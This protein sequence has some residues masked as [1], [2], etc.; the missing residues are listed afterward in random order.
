MAKRQYGVLSYGVFI[1]ILAICIATFAAGLI[2]LDEVF[3]LV[4]AFSG[5]WIVILAG[6]RATKPEKYER[7]A[8]STFS[9]GTLITAVGTVWFLYVRGFA[10]WYLLSALLLVLGILTMAAVL[11][12]R[13]K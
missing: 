13:R 1:V 6:I 11:R 3:P 7:G 4:L 5:V 12:P 9:W 8:F 2:R 10:F